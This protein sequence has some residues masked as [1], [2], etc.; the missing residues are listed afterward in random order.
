MKAGA[1]CLVRLQQ[2]LATALP[3]SIYLLWDYQDHISGSPPILSAPLSGSPRLGKWSK[4]AE[5]G[6]ARRE[7]SEADT[8]KLTTVGDSEL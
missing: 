7:C 8:E 1:S 5:E 6:E 3:E 4:T 2:M